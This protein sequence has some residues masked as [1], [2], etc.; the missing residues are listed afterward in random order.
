M[1][2][3]FSVPSKASVLMELREEEKESPVTRQN[4]AAGT[5]PSALIVAALDL[6]NQQ[7]V[8]WTF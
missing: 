4:I 3:L 6:E 8:S 5:S 1:I 7:Y 2:G